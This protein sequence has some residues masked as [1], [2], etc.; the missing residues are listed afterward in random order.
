M[1]DHV[2]QTDYARIDYGRE[3]RIVRLDAIESD[4]VEDMPVG[5]LDDN[6]PLWI[7]V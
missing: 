6:T 1:N 5:I 2:M 4:D 3:G 7:G